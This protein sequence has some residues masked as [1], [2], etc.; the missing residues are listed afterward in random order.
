MMPKGSLNYVFCI[1]YRE[2]VLRERFPLDVSRVCH[3]HKNLE[4]FEK[5]V[6]RNPFK[7]NVG[8]YR[9]IFF[10]NFEIRRGRL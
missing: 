1:G 8:N 6:P 4:R 10:I 5:Q 9:N 7:R 2:P 3:C